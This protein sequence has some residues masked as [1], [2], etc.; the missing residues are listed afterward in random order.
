MLHEDLMEAYVKIL[1]K[2]K[3]YQERLRL[4]FESKRDLMKDLQNLVS[5]QRG[6]EEL[7][8]YF[9]KWKIWLI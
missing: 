2:A 6:N 1:K 3:G 4:A 7:E 9:K 8:V 5:Y